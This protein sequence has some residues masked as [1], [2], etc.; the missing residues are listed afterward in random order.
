MEQIWKYETEKKYGLEVVSMKK[1]RNIEQR[2]E[3]IK[4]RKYGIEVE[5]MKLSN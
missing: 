2:V 1:R 3:T 5:S 4:E